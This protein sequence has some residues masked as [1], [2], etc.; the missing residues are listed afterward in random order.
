MRDKIGNLEEVGLKLI[1]FLKIKKL[2]ITTG[3][4]GVILID[5][6]GKF[7]SLDKDLKVISSKVDFESSFKLNKSKKNTYNFTQ[8]NC[9]II[10]SVY[11]RDFLIFNYERKDSYYQKLN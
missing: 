8:K 9:D 5:Y 10:E 1:K 3:S 4:K 6:V 7:E 11:L 2:V